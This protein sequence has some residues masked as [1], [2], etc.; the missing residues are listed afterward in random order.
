MRFAYSLLFY[1][2]TPFVLLYFA[3]RGRKDKRYL[4]RWSERFG[5]LPGALKKRGI[6]VHAASVGEVNASRELVASL[7]RHHPGLP[8][9]V[10]TLTPTGS[11]QVRRVLG[12]SVGHCFIPLDL[13]GAVNRFLDRLEPRLVII[14]ETEIWPNLYHGAHCREIPLMLA[15]ARLSKRSL[16]R[17]RVA[18]EF[19]A[20]ALRRVAWVGAQSADDHRRLVECGADA[21]AVRM[22][23]NLK[24]DM[25]VPG[26]LGERASSVR[27]HWGA[28]R[29]VLVAGSTH[30][31]DEAV[32]IPAF[33]ELLQKMPDALLVLAPRHPERFS[34]VAQSAL[35][36]GLRTE[37]YSQGEACSPQ[38]Q[39][40]VID[41][42]GELMT[43]YACG[44]I[45]YVGG[46]IGEQGGHNALEPAALGIPVLFG[47]NMANARDIAD[48]LLSCNA[49]QEVSNSRE[50]SEVVRRVLS[51]E[52]LR[53]RM[54]QAGRELVISN[55]GAL[56]ATLSAVRNFV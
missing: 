42:V 34:R 24:F 19:I 44:D 43:Y 56:K 28:R 53:N 21:D 49:A 33:V 54:G 25:D 38:A 50:F 40:F 9:T 51:D 12:D 8:V 10:S 14:I 6:L 39:C 55:K 48:R 36:S 17:Y 29:K 18:A 7:L 1:L 5:F 47:P 32:V 37:L 27:A 4:Q 22:T 26:N 20:R 11:A 16:K 45:A 3:L 31:E 46:G 52:N 30:E 15:N 13:P 35:D 23:G 2:A 41:T